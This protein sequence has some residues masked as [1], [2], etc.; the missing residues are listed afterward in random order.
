MNVLLYGSLLFMAA[1]VL[2]VVVWRIRLPKR[3]TKALLFI[4][5]G[6]LACG[7]LLLFKYPGTIIILG[8]HPPVAVPEYCRI[9]L[10]FVSLTLAYMITYSAIEAD[11]PSLM[12]ILKI[13]KP[14]NRVWMKS[15]LRSGWTIIS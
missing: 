11:S 9:W 2:H 6:V 8:L 13:A 4:F 1:F 10:Y 15:C 5:F 7:S 12:I 3:Q 14:A